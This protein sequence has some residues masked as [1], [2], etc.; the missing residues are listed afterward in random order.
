[1]FQMDC[2]N[3]GEVIKSPRLVDVQVIDCPHC[4]K[5]VGV[6]NVVVAR[7]KLSTNL[8]TSLKKALLGAKDNFR[9]NKSQ[10]LDGES[11]YTIDKRLA[12]LL[13]RDD[14]R[15]GLPYDLYVQINFNGNKRLARL[16]NISPQGAGVEFVERSR[17]PENDADVN[18]RLPENDSEIDFLLPLPGETQPLS[19]TGK[20]VW[21]KIPEKGTIFPS[22]PMGVKFQHIN[23][24]TRECLWDFIINSEASPGQQA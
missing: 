22:I 12:K 8:R 13:R 1:M 15:L 16:L 4:E 24:Q 9:K 17:L 5:I 2:S 10:L 3:C 23:E 18:L 7:K 11:K 20:V 6:M 14:F 21:S 19:L